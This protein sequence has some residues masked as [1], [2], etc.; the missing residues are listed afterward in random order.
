MESTGKDVQIATHCSMVDL[1]MPW[2][3]DYSIPFVEV[4][5]VYA[6]MFFSFSD[7]TESN[8]TLLTTTTD[9]LSSS[10]STA[11]TTSTNDSSGKFFF[12]RRKKDFI[13]VQKLSISLLPIIIY[14][15]RYA[16]VFAEGFRRRL[17][18]TSRDTAVTA[19]IFKIRRLQNN[20][21]IDAICKLLNILSVMNVPRNLKAI[22]HQLDN[23][24]DLTNFYQCY[25]LCSDCGTTTSDKIISCQL[26]HNKVIFK[27]YLCSI[28]QE[29]QQL[30][31][32]PGF[33]NKMKEEKVKNIHL[34]SN[35]KYGEILREIENDSFTMIINSDGVCTPNKNLSLWPF[36]LMINELPIH[37]RRYLE[38]ITIA[39]II[40]TSKKPTNAV[41]QNCLDLIYEQMIQLESGQE[42]YVKDLDERKIL[43]FYTVA[44]CTDKPAEALMENVVSYNAAYGC[45]KCFTKGIEMFVDIDLL[46]YC[47]MSI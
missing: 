42:F 19:M 24:F 23:Q 27:F 44:S 2:S 43:H 5:W 39:G 22:E 47:F 34:F 37:E 33:Y 12:L 13:Y 9:S 40:P 18:R 31:S 1:Q 41:F 20:K 11:I 30:L 7:P 36:I 25:H 35:T 16:F 29:L 14:S 32:T 8:P 15:R 26:C 38:N 10:H 28:K 17:Q 3:S 4:Y 21:D 46:V 6:P 45:P